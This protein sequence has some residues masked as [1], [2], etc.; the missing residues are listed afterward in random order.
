MGRKGSPGSFFCFVLFCFLFS[1]FLFFFF[2]PKKGKSRICQRAAH[3]YL[4]AAWTNFALTGKTACI[5]YQEQERNGTVISFLTNSRQL[6]CVCVCVCV[7]V[8]LFW[9]NFISSLALCTRADLGFTLGVAPS[10]ASPAS[11][12]RGEADWYP[13]WVPGNSHLTTERW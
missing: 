5:I 3:S 9:N 13:L 4:A 7:C 2:Y 12:N 1:F 11:P 10:A 6:L 8:C